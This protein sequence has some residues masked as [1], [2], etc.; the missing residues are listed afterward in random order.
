MLSTLAQESAG[1]T[2]NDGAWEFAEQAT[3]TSATASGTP[4]SSSDATMQPTLTLSKKQKKKSA[5]KQKLQDDTGGTK[6]VRFGTCEELLFCREVG[7]DG[8]PSKGS[9][10]LGLGDKL[11]MR[12][13]IPVDEYIQQQQLALRSRAI[14]NAEMRD[15]QAATS[16]HKGGHHAADA[17]HGHAHG[18]AARLPLIQDLSPQSILETRQ[19]D[20]KAGYRNTLFE[21]TTEEERLMLLGPALT[22]AKTSHKVVAGSS[23][24]QGIADLNKD[25]HTIRASRDLTGCSCKALKLDKLSVVKMKNELR[26][27]GTDADEEI[28]KLSKADLIDRVRD[29]LKQCMMCTENNCECVQLQVP[30]SAEVCGCLKHGKKCANIVLEEIFDPK[31]V[32]EYRKKVLSEALII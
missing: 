25:I 26:R 27:A 10:A 9:Y 32:S 13:V 28:E 19:C 4:S 1:I 23:Q 29:V 2:F 16:A 3:R 30:C 6:S 20:Y 18:H 11:E 17:A 31:R 21:S 12:T 24:L 7:F 14:H 22:A 5:K 15:L 8:I